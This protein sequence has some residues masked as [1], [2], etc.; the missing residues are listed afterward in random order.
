MDDTDEIQ[1]RP[2]AARSHNPVPVGYRQGIITAITVFLGFSLSFFRFWGFEAGGNWDFASEMAAAAFVMAVI[3][4]IIALFRS[5]RVEDD[6]VDEY[7]KTV[8]WF[9][10]S[11]VVL[12]V[13][14]VF[15]TIIYSETPIPKTQSSSHE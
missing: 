7:R 12:F 4:Q 8:Y 11:I 6:D 2:S 9:V 3:L 15:A 10:A 1:P 14:L 13:G 5:L